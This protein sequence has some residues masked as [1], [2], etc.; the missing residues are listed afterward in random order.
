M[1]QLEKAKQ[2]STAGLG[3]SPV[4]FNIYTN[5]L[6]ATESRKFIYADDICFAYQSK[7][8][9]R[10]ND[11]LKENLHRISEYCNRWRLNLLSLSKAVSSV[12]HL[13]HAKST[14]ELNIFLNGT[15]LKLDPKPKYQGIALDRTLIFKPHLQKT[16]A[17]IR[18]R[19]KLLSMLAGTT[20]GVSATTLR[21]SALALCYSTA[22][23]CTQKTQSTVT[24]SIRS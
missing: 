12:F 17:K 22:E 14:M 24:K 1:Q 8:S 21:C 20:W 15:R 6:P 4:L 16:A 2:R 9:S 13:H 5:D 7:N 11:I 18:T 19:N 10:L 3:T 23:Y